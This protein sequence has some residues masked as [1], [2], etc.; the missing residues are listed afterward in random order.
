MGLFGKDNRKL[1]DYLGTQSQLGSSPGVFARCPPRGA[2]VSSPW[3]LPW[4]LPRGVSRVIS[5][6][7]PSEPGQRS[8]PASCVPCS[9]P[10]G[11]SRVISRVSDIRGWT[12]LYSRVS[13]I[14]GRTVLISHSRVV[15]ITGRTVL[16]SRVP[17]FRAWSNTMVPRARHQSSWEA[18]YNGFFLGSPPFRMINF[19]F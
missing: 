14:T 4:N 7:R 19:T 9:L 15:A 18:L 5:R 11:V 12:V 17:A 10:C 6:C 16:Y 13:A 2:P 8:T 1:L 3:C